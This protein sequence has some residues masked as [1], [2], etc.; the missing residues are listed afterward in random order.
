MGA[1]WANQSWGRYWAWDSK[2]VWALI[3]ML[4]Y[5]APLHSSLQWLRKPLHIHIY[6]LLAFLCVLMTYF[7]ANYFLAGMHS[8]A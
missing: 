3:T 8:Y 6:M 5:S 1:V 4:I 7:G 2:E